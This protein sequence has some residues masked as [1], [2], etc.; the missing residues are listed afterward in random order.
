MYIL[1]SMSDFIKHIFSSE[2]NNYSLGL[3]FEMVVQESK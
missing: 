1:L 2:K 3:C